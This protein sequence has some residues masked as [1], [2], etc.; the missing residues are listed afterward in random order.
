MDSPLPRGQSLWDRLPRELEDEVLQ[1]AEPIV[2]LATGRITREQAE[3][4]PGTV[5]RRLWFE[6][7]D[8]DLLGV[9]ARLPRCELPF[10][11][12]W[13]LRSRAL[14]DEAAA[15]GIPLHRRGLQHAAAR[16]RW[17]DALELGDDQA[18]AAAVLAA[19][20][21]ALS[22]LVGMADR[23]G[24]VLTE[25]MAQSAAF[26]GHADVVEFLHSRMPDGSWSPG[27]MD[28]A[29]WGGNIAIVR[30]LNEHRTEGCTTDA[31]DWAASEGHLEVLK[32]LHAHRSE[33][34][35]R[36]ALDMAAA[37]GFLDVVRWLV[38][39]RNERGA[40]NAITWATE[41][42]SD[43]VVEWLKTNLPVTTA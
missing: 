27:V 1:H 29:A 4:L 25:A 18:Q 24:V 30:F 37:G 39:E 21:G 7:L 8:G 33:G 34:C 28:R 14:Y 36:S 40:G 19:Q 23:P 13:R 9:A 2:R 15:L 3:A 38:T 16:H 12:F 42:G 11:F 10:R 35:S 31:M 22:L 6:T 17:D 43:D 26:W 20:A 32:F 41:T 5:Q